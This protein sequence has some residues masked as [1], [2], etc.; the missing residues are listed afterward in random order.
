MQSSSDARTKVADGRVGTVLHAADLHL[1]APLK[2]LGSR[3]DADVTAHIRKLAT[4]AYD[5]LVSLALAESVDVVVL[6]GDVYD[7]AEYEVA[8]QLRF[9]EGLRRMTEAGIQVFIAHG[10][11]DPLTKKFKLAAKMPDGVT[12]F[13]A[14]EPQVH[15]VQLRS[16]HDLSVAGISFGKQ[17][18]TANL[19]KLFHGLDTPVESTVGVLHCNV[20]TNTGHDPY[21]PC[22]VTDLETAP[23][24]YWALGHIHIRD[25]NEMGPGRW[26]AYPGNLQGRS[27]KAAECGEKGVL[28]VPV[29]SGGFGRPEFRACADVRF[30]RVPVDVTGC[31]DVDEVLSAIDAAMDDVS[32]DVDSVVA[33]VELIGRSAAHRQLTALGADGLLTSVQEM[34]G[35][36]AAKAVSKVE[37]STGNQVDLDQIR[38]RGGLLGS[39]VERFAATDELTKMFES[40]TGGLDAAARKRLNEM[41][42]TDPGLAAMI[43][44]RAQELLIDQLDDAS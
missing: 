14:G 37:L 16:G 10:N 21:A 25:V 9:V 33:R 8:A 42:A 44:E 18:E 11:H 17:A 40:V 43:C 39:L 6:A 5:N 41:L 12:V 31:D 20:G 3:L 19:A 36:S 35:T 26:R 15:P 7:D 4:R 13:E 34:L 23:V 22:S 29:M 24:G 38:R 1:G 32:V 27:S 28:L 2:A 30:E